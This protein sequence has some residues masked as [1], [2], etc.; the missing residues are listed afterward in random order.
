MILKSMT[1]LRERRE[2]VYVPVKCNIALVEGGSEE[3]GCNQSVSGPQNIEYHT[4]STNPFHADT[5]TLRAVSIVPPIT[6]SFC[7]A[8]LVV[9]LHL[10][11]RRRRPYQRILES[12]RTGTEW[13]EEGFER[14][15]ESGS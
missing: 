15:H 13:L 10:R 7:L 1:R 5:D 12:A 2:G 8:E 11:S 6:T 3:E 14:I 4:Q 9:K